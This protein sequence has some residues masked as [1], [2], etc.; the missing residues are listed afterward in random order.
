VVSSHNVIAAIATAPGRAGIGVVRVSGERL[1]EFARAVCGKRLQPR[2]ATLCKF[3]DMQGGL[4]DHGI[5]LYFQA[6]QSYT[7]EDVLE[8]QGHGGPVVLGRLLKRCLDLGARVAEPG[9]FSKR[10]YLNGKMD[11]AQAEGVADLI[12]AATEEAARCANRS[13]QGEFSAEIHALAQQLVALRALTEATLDFPEEEID[14]GTRDD[15]ANA[16]KTLTHRLQ[17]VLAV[18]RQGSLLREGALVA[19][20]GLPNAGKSSLLNRLAGEEVAIVTDIPGTTR[21]AIRQSINLYGMPVHFMDTAGLRESSDPLEQMGMARTWAALDKANL[22]VLVI[23]VTK[24]GSEQDSAIISKLPKGLQCIKA[25]NKA[26]LAASGQTKG[27]SLTNGSVMLSARTGEGIEE[28]RLAIAKAIGWRGN[29]EGVYMARA[30]HLE[31]L[32]SALAALARAEREIQRQEFFAEELR[33][34]HEALM[35]IT[36]EVSSDDLLGEIFSHFCI[37]K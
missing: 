3:N 14:S 34:A 33:E 36:G 18:S 26:D 30:R 31:A 29:A 24:G 16:L 27:I 23:D 7:G 19:L 15:Q 6:P 10:A 25:Y 37:G 20:V 8:L 13:I 4:I 1:G 28:L 11:L 17:Q 9:E 12:E 2:L 35:S 22:A 5:A 32:S 21:D